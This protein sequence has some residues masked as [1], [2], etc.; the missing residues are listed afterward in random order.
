M[1]V[2]LDMDGVIADFVTASIKAHGVGHVVNAEACQHWD[3]F[4]KWKGGMTKKQFWSK[5]MS[6]EFWV[7]IPAYPWTRDLYRLIKSVDHTVK[8][9]TSPSKDPGCL[10]GKMEWLDNHLNLTTSD[11]I[12]IHEK[13]RLADPYSLLID[14]DKKKVKQFK[15]AGGKAILFSGVNNDWEGVSIEERL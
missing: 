10:T 15:E 12:F 5:C 11:V 3:Y 4:A 9:A 2:Y 6:H 14:D 1:K 7:N 8:I 13:W